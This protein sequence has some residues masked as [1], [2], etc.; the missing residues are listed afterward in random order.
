MGDAPQ[1]HCV[2]LSAVPLFPLP[3]VVLF[4]RAVLP[5]H[6]FEQRYKA[7]T[8]DALAGAGVIA[9]ALLRRGWEK[10]YYQAPAIDPVVCVGRI[11]SYEKL[12]DGNYNFLLQGLLRARVS[13]EDRAR[14]YRLASVVALEESPVMEIDLANERQKLTCM[15]SSGAASNL[16]IVRQF[17]TMLA[18]PM[19][20]AH[21]ADL[22]A[23]TFIDD[24]AA[25]KQSLLAE[26]DVRQR[27]ERL[28][29]ALQERQPRLEAQAR[30][31]L[32]DVRD[33]GSVN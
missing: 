29:I 30:R 28:I 21:V 14:P 9:M 23:F 3:D 13:S 31:R 7:M 15:L 18:S 17:R 2:D 11:V 22:L 25:L 19:P 10:C 5:L 26:T 1:P 16:P 12:P 33:L 27:V 8:A 24:D 32:R 20:T 6:I 4:P